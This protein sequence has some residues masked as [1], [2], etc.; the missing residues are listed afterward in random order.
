MEANNRKESV[1]VIK[2]ANILTGPE[3][4]KASKH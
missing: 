4:Q 2:E 1:P 3:R